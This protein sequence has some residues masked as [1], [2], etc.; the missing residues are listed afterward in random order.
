MCGN[1][2][3]EADKEKVKLIKNLLKLEKDK[4]A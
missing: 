2:M 4:N 3:S 1:K